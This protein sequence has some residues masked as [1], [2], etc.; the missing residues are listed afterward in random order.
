MLSFYVEHSEG[1]TQI[2]RRKFR[3]DFI[4]QAQDLEGMFKATAH[5][6]ARDWKELLYGIME[7]FPYYY[8]TIAPADILRK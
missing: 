3:N 6:V 8:K 1:H 5:L 4:L 2:G 7:Y